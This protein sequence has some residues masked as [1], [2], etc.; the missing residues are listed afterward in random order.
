[1]DPRVA[2]VLFVPRGTLS[3]HVARGLLPG[4]LREALIEAGRAEETDLRAEDL[5]AGFFVGNAVRG[6][7]AA[8]LASSSP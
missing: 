7:V 2:P 5:D 1:M 4:V 6:L 8:R 3:T